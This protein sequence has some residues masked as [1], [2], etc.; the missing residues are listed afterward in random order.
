MYTFFGLSWVPIIVAP[1]E[2]NLALP[3]GWVRALAGVPNYY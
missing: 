2:D 3:L 1:R